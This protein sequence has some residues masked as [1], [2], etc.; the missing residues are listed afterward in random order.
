[1]ENDHTP[2]MAKNGCV[3]FTAS[4]AEAL[5]QVGWTCLTQVAVNLEQLRGHRSAEALH[6]AR[7]GLSRL[8]A[9]LTLFRPMVAGAGLAQIKAETQWLAG[10]LDVARDLDVFIRETFQHS[11]PGHEHRAGRRA[12]RSHLVGAQACAYRRVLT[13]VESPRYAELLLTTAAWLETGD[14]T[15]SRMPQP[16][17]YRRMNAADFARPRL[18]RLRRKVLKQGRKIALLDAP[19]LHR[20]RI[21][22][23]KL[24]YAA[25]FFTACFG[26]PGGKQQKFLAALKD[27]QHHLGCLNDIVAA[28]RLADG[29]ARGQKAKVAL[30]AHAIV[31]RRQAAAPKARKAALNAFASV[32]NAKPFWR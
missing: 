18:D 9:G 8:R 29:L 20:L 2:L 32:R 15:R 11:R 5:R 30:A 14:W 23:K 10:E 22:V 31:E 21:K 25:E 1:M 19:K 24:R 3:I 26:A 27:L 7:V 16:A 12:L 6:Q 4:A 17:R 13:A 28:G